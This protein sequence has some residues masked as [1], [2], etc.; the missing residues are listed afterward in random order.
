MM[1]KQVKDI[2]FHLR[3][4]HKEIILYYDQ[5]ESRAEM[6]AVRQLLT[7]LRRNKDGFMSVIERYEEQGYPP[8]MEMW[9]QF[10]P[11]RSL[12]K[13]V[14]NFHFRDDMSV[15][16]VT[17]LALHF[18]NWLEDILRHLTEK[19]GTEEARV[20]F[21]ALQ[22]VLHEDKRRLATNSALMKDL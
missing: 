8:V 5:L 2:L 12:D 14:E 10:S 15:E 16:E 18:D 6:R 11:E 9:I 20:V 19:S 13:E 21:N 7:H 22:D 1:F 17:R 3:K 4:L